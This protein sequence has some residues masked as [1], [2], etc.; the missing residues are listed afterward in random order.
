LGGAR[1]ETKKRKPQ[2]AA[3]LVRTLTG[4]IFVVGGGAGLP[5]LTH[6]GRGDGALQTRKGRLLNFRI[7]FRQ[8]G[9]VDQNQKGFLMR[10][11]LVCLCGSLRGRRRA[12]GV[13]GQGAE[14]RLQVRPWGS[15]AVM[16][17]KQEG[18]LWPLQES[19]V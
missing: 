14:L 5:C 15:S 1:S 4:S 12:T 13:P 3:G 6:L 19:L 8:G 7:P 10:K 11:M 2:A 16:S 18:K 17:S 9:M